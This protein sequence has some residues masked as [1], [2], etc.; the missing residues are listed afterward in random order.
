[1]KD[2]RIDQYIKKSA[3]FA[4][5]IL[6]HLRALVHQGCPGVEETIKRSMPAFVHQGL[7]CMMAAFKQHAT[8]HFWRHK[9]VVGKISEKEAMGEFGRI[10]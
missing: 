3:D 8:L 9:L 5:P 4:Q 10:T 7:L 2:P 1:M 6:E